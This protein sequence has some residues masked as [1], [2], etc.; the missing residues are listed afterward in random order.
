MRVVQEKLKEVILVSSCIAK[1]GPGVEI[2]QKDRKG[3]KHRGV[4]QSYA[5]V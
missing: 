4:R 2:G 1:E 5:S 3:G